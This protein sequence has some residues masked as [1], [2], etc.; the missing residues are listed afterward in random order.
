[1]PRRNLGRDLEAKLGWVIGVLWALK[2]TPLFF[3]TPCGIFYTK[4]EISEELI[5]VRSFRNR[6]RNVSSQR[7][8][9][10]THHIIARGK[11][12]STS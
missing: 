12:G 2:Q 1:M 3:G 6:S 9:S 8:Y 11:V 5:S 7:V 10:I 4:R